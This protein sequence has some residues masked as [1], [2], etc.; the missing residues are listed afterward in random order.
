[1]KTP[2]NVA[3]QYAPQM[4]ENRARV[5]KITIEVKALRLSIREFYVWR[6]ELRNG[7]HVGL[8]S[9]VSGPE[10]CDAIV[11]TEPE[12]GTTL[13]RALSRLTLPT[14]VSSK[15][16]KPCES[17]EVLEEEQE[18]SHEGK[19][20]QDH[21]NKEANRYKFEIRLQD[22]MDLN[23]FDPVW[24]PEWTFPGGIPKEIDEYVRGGSNGGTCRLIT[25]MKTIVFANT[26]SQQ[27]TKQW[28]HHEAFSGL[29]VTI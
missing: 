19:S 21:E 2:R 22:E 10:A 9:K 13:D 6:S 28:A 17:E 26:Y 8:L 5:R 16:E 7:T 3:R 1:M 15:V 4:V 27:H 23:L 20:V 14:N 29:K 12:T 25:F 11:Q 24:Q 18:Q